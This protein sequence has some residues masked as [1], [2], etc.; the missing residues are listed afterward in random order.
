M[1]AFRYQNKKNPQPVRLLVL[2]DFGFVA[3]GGIETVIS[4]LLP[5][6]AISCEA[7]VWVL[8]EYKISLATSRLI[9]K[10]SIHLES[11]DSSRWQPGWYTKV[12]LSIVSRIDRVNKLLP[13]HLL[14]SARVKRRRLQSIIKHY[15]L[16]HLLNVGVFDQPFP[17]VGIPIFGIV[18]DTNYTPDF[19]IA[20]IKN[21]EAWAQRA[22]GIFTVS[23]W[24]R[25]QICLKVPF[26]RKKIYDVPIAVNQPQFCPQTRQQ[27]NCNAITSFLY[28]ASFSFH[29]NHLALLEAFAVLHSQGYSYKLFFCGYNTNLLLSTERLLEP[30]LEA[31]RSFLATSSPEFKASIRVLGLIEQDY[32]ERIYQQADYVLLPSTYEGFG[33]PLTEAVARGVPVLC[34]DIPP[35]CEQI[36]TFG[37]DKYVTIV[38]GVDADNWVLAIREVLH[39]SPLKTVSL[40]VIHE[41]LSKWK[42]CDVASA[43]KRI[44]QESAC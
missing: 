10:E 2:E 16:T 40:P 39:E 23:A 20:C 19:R 5:E 28:P 15:G 41:T 4:S 29:K 27:S 1:Q 33:L 11:L 38:Q 42:W 44:M 34:S 36:K 7:L 37:L 26:A 24:S 35:F 17:E 25:K 32:L 43:Y 30:R 8:P 3:N 9:K 12:L 31:A 14:L 18:H 21:L 6:L 22:E 13:L